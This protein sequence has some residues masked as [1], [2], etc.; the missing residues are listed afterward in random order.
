MSSGLRER[1]QQEVGAEGFRL[2]M[3]LGTAR[4]SRTWLAAD[5]ASR[6][7]VLRRLSGVSESER[8]ALLGD[9]ERMAQLRHPCLL[10]PSSGWAYETAAWVA[11]LHDDGVSLRRLVAVARLTPRHV[12]A[13][14]SDVLEGLSALDK[15]GLAH[16]SLHSG[17]ILVGGNGRAR[18]AD[19]GL[20]AAAAGEGAAGG[21]AP[22]EESDAGLS[23]L[24][25]VALAMRAALGRGGAPVPQRVVTGGVDGMDSLIAEG[26]PVLG[27]ARCPREALEILTRLTGEPDPGARR[28]IAALVAPLRH[29]RSLGGRLSRQAITPEGRDTLASLAPAGASALPV[30]GEPSPP[31][32]PPRPGAPLSPAGAP[33][34]QTEPAETG[35]RPSGPRIA[36]RP[37]GGPGATG[38]RRRFQPRRAPHRGAASAAGLPSM[39]PGGRAVLWALPLAAALVVAGLG[40]ALHPTRSAPP[41]L[42]AAA[43]PSS[44]APVAQPTPRVQPPPTSPSTPAT[45]RPAPPTPPAPPTAGGVAR[46]TVSAVGSG[47]CTATAG[48]QCDLRVEVQLV[49]HGAEMVAWELLVVDGCTGSELVTPGA[50]VPASPGLAYVWAD[51]RVT[52]QSADPVTLFA[53]TTQP[54]RAASPGLAVGG[55]GSTC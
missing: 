37:P 8:L 25:A 24:E 7:C 39:H 44:E 5:R 48:S 29:E 10:S 26:A 9:V 6:L 2:L 12:A 49:A 11:R 17:N 3:L 50:A 14:G 16:G 47:G 28:Q 1:D 51:S 21:A 18:I 20:R 53:V 52:F 34:D 42:V 54:A 32:P 22:V 27:G 31:A 55:A 41:P 4:T 35:G 13:L 46:L 15:V 23:D 43:P 33:G 30:A 36:A 38:F 40:V 19:M 45:S